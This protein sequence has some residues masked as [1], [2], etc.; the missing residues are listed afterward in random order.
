MAKE[1]NSFLDDIF[2]EKFQKLEDI[3]SLEYTQSS[4]DKVTKTDVKDPNFHKELKRAL[5]DIFNFSSVNNVNLVHPVEFFLKYDSYF[6]DEEII[7]AYFSLNNYEATLKYIECNYERIKKAFQNTYLTFASIDDDGEFGVPMDIEY[8]FELEDIYGI[9]VKQNQIYTIPQA[10]NEHSLMYILYKYFY[11]DISVIVL[12]SY[13]DDKTD[14]LHAIC[15]SL[16]W[17]Y[18]K[19]ILLESLE[20]KDYETYN[21]VLNNYVGKNTYIQELLEEEPPFNSLEFIFE[22]FKSQITFEKGFYPYL[23]NNG[24][25]YTFL[26]LEKNK[27]KE[28]KESTSLANS[29]I[30]DESLANLKYLKALPKKERI[31][32]EVYKN[33]F[34]LFYNYFDSFFNFDIS[35]YKYMFERLFN[36]I[37]EGDSI[38]RLIALSNIESI[39][40]YFKT[41]ETV[42]LDNK[43]VSLDDIK[44]YNTKQYLEIRKLIYS[45]KLALVLYEDRQFSEDAIL[46]LRTFGYDKTKK[47][48]KMNIHRLCLSDLAKHRFKSEKAKHKFVE[49]FDNELELIQKNIKELPKIL[50]I[51]EYLFENNYPKITISKIIKRLNSCEIVLLPNNMIIKKN[52]E[53]LD[54]VSKGEPLYDK[55]NGITL[56]NEYRLRNISSIPDIYGSVGSLTYETVDMHSPEIISN[57]I[58]SYLHS[59]G[60]MSSSCLTPAGKAASCLHHGATSPHG[61]FFKVSINK[62]IVAYSWVWRRGNTLCFDNIEVTDEINKYNIQEEQIF[63]CYKKVAEEMKKITCD[64]EKNPIKVVLIGRNNLDIIT[65][66]FDNLKKTHN[67]IKPNED[68]TLYL[69][70]SEDGEYILMGDEESINLDEVTPIYKYRRKPVKEVSYFEDYDIISE[71]NSIYFDYCIFTNIKYQSKEWKYKKCYI[72]E[73]WFIGYKPDGTFDFFYRNNNPDIQKEAS[74]YLNKKVEVLSPFQI[75]K[76]NYR[77]LNSF[78]NCK[79][80]KY[81]EAEVSEYLKSI[82]DYLNIVKEESYYH[83]AR[84][85]RELGCILYDGAITSSSY[86]NH[87]GGSGSNGKHFICV[88]EMNSD[89]YNSLI[90][91]EGFIIDGNICTFDTGIDTDFDFRESRY[92]IRGQGGPGE[93][94]VL[95][96]ISLNKVKALKLLNH[97]LNI[98]M[99]TYIEEDAGTNLPFVLEEEFKVLDKNEIKRLIKFN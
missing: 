1:E 87:D 32:T 76:G 97:P 80:Y 52:L 34:Y 64:N 2:V 55:L 68:K 28:A 4:I 41:G 15:H 51:F 98:G 63:N 77:N 56:Y 84:N 5:Q 71:L 43:I 37:I 69:K 13:V 89:L 62:K 66:P 73:D 40:H 26:E 25:I 90:R 91:A 70:D 48:I 95:D 31:K 72:G 16:R 96:Y 38:F 30:S 78:L 8:I 22:A 67:Q 74:K 10:Y 23:K 29:F 88:A 24:F 49:I 6:T 19:K 60:E 94:Q 75:V 7:D 36:R 86:G 92:P 35:E 45:E 81:N 53:E 47:Y 17:P 61:R 14:K 18:L 93:K 33:A 82:K 79:R 99:I 39:Y 50:R 46:L 54:K 21:K 83:K 12:S 42:N 85:L 27:R 20:K 9:K 65:K 44:A 11:N 58:G 3:F 59:N 57:G